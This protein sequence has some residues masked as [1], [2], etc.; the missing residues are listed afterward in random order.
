ML[1]GLLGAVRERGD[2]SRV[3]LAVMREDGP[4]S[5]M[6]VV[7]AD[8]RIC[9][10]GSANLTGA[11]LGLRNLELGVILLGER[12]ADVDEILDLFLAEATDERFEV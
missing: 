2:R 6:K 10:I 5:H 9:Y 8:G 4:W 3:S 11:G 7:V 12:V 1:S